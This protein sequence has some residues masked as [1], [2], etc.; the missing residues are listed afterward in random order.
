M[1]TPPFPTIIRVFLVCSV[2]WFLMTSK[3]FPHTSC[4]NSSCYKPCLC[5]AMASV[6]RGIWSTLH[7]PPSKRLHGY[8][9]FLTI[10]KTFPCLLCNL[11]SDDIKVSS[12]TLLVIPLPVINRAYVRLWPVWLGGDLIPLLHNPPCKRLHRLRFISNHT[13]DFSLFAL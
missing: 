5:A 12:P 9:L 4:H 11:V 8:T 2:T 6:A 13:R 7:N 1:V 3:V 10:H